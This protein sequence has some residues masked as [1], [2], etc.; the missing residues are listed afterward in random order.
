MFTDDDDDIVPSS[1]REDYFTKSDKGKMEE[2]ERKAEQKMGTVKAA[3]VSKTDLMKDVSLK[4]LKEEVDEETSSFAKATEDK[5]DAQK[6]APKTKTL[7]EEEE[8]Q[9]EKADDKP[10]IDTFIERQQSQQE[11]EETEVQDQPG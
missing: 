10:D 6:T 8:A 3:E 7:K 4:K 5:R 2:I 9:I 11:V 1:S